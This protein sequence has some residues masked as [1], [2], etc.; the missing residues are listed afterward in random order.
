MEPEKHSSQYTN[1]ATITRWVA[2]HRIERKSESRQL[3]AK[4]Q[5]LADAACGQAVVSK[6]TTIEKD[7]IV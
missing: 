6:Q 3:V 7:R 1:T 5:K 4:T 2:E